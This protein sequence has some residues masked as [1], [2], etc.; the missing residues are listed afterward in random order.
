[1]TGK[2]VFV[3]NEPIDHGCVAVALGDS[4]ECSVGIGRDAAQDFRGAGLVAAREALCGLADHASML[5]LMVDVR[6][7][8]LADAIAG[9]YEIAG[10]DVPLAGGASSGSDPAQYAN[11]E[12]LEDAVV[13]IA[14]RSSRPIGIG[15]AHS[16]S[17][18]G[19][20]STVTSSDGQLIAEIDGRP[21]CDVYLERVGGRAAL[22]DERFEQMAITH[23]LAQPEEHG[24][25]RLRHILGRTPAG[26]LRC[27]THIGAG[28]KV[29][30][31]VLSLDE[32]VRSGLDSVAGSVGS[33][34]NRDPAAALIFDCAGRRKVLG[35]GQAQ[36]VA[37]ITKSFGDP[38]P[39][40]AG[41]YTDGEV[42]RIRG[43]RGDHN[44]SVVT[45]AIA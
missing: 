11:G 21:A 25:R 2:G 24:N 20:P 34:A 41:L 27:S 23:P 9:A 42:A 40:F 28:E 10:P 1:M 13:A 22:D 4:V 35:H 38:P 8:D 7:G 14:V 5:M 26:A 33:L 30:F 18:V 36:E 17:V 3:A 6:A 44:H 19:E 12:A 31:T 45:V 16:C 37:A 15:N 29:E 43:T 32:L 39:P